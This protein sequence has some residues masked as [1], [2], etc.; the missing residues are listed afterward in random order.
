MIL[1]TGPGAMASAHADP[2]AGA[3]LS[4]NGY[5]VHLGAPTVYNLNADQL[6]DTDEPGW[7][8]RL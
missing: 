6:V 8:D 4:D 3:A 7:L 2:V 5:A 1:L